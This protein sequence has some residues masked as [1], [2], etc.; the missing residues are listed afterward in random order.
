MLWPN[1]SPA[2]GRRGLRNALYLLRQV[3]G[4][5]GVISLGEHLVGVNRLTVTCDALLLE[6]AE[7]APASGF[8]DEGWDPGTLPFGGLVLDDAPAF[9]QW[10]EGE[11]KRIQEVR[12]HLPSGA[13][14]RPGQ[15]RVGSSVVRN[16]FDTR[17]AGDLAG[18]AHAREPVTS[19]LRGHYLF[20]RGSHGGSPGELE[21]SRVCFER[22]LEQ[23]PDFAPALAGLAN[24]HAVT[25]RRGSFADF[26]TDF[27]RAIAYSERAALL[28][29]S[30]AIPHVHFGVQALYLNDAWEVA[31]RE[32]ATA[33]FKEP[34]YAEGRRFYG[35]WLGLA[36]RHQEALREMEAAARL[37]PD[38]PHI[39]SSLGAARIAV[40]DVAGAEA[41]LRQTLALD[42]RHRA[43]R[44]RLLR[45]LEDSGR[46]DLA[47]DEAG[48][49]PVWPEFAAYQ[50]AWQRSG[51]D[52]YRS[53]R[54][55]EMLRE[56][57][58]LENRL[59]ERP[60]ATVN[61]LFS[62]PEVRLVV[63]LRQL[64]QSRRAHA[65][66]LEACARRPILTH[67]FTA[68]PEQRDVLRPDR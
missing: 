67:W 42:P 46:L 65:W 16:G 53:A 5:D 64:G 13:N 29:P 20:L 33:A 11:R 4:R 34:E 44:E 26:R 48:R 41:A 45:L 52:G 27:D 19:Y 36:S 56:V 37:E 40:G 38:I 1:E 59:T 12:R 23:D 50:E 66:Q 15:A 60:E 68:L 39:L 21:Q 6:A 14:K 35:V 24:F 63:L 22:A 28:D 8:R 2:Q 18:H 61:D 7:P 31:G 30:L 51:E 55:T 32:F 57:E 54:R 25:A 43:A 9:M 58:T 47:L 17:G 10:V 3:I 62:P 49:A